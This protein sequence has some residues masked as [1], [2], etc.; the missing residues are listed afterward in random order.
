MRVIR[1]IRL[2]GVIRVIRVIRIIGGIRVIRVI[3]VIEV[4]VRQRVYC[5][6]HCCSTIADFLSLILAEAG[7]VRVCGV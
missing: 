4:C 6:S 5:F 7:R 3:R 1:V 2:I